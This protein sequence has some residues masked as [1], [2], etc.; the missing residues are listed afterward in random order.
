MRVL[1]VLFVIVPIAEM[2][3]LIKIGEQI[4]AT[5]TILAVLLTAVLGVALLRQQGLNTLFRVNQ[6]LEQG[7]L[8]AEEIIG[9]LCLAVGGALLLT[10]GFITD[11]AGFLCLLP[12]SRHLLVRFL[13]SHS[14]WQ[15]DTDSF[16]SQ[17]VFREQH[18]SKT[19]IE[20]E[21]KREE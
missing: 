21:F 5:L 9:G 10:P 2:W 11:V 16:D 1:F 3:L 14:R 12:I 15:E 6:R 7:Q 17:T 18:R 4:G 19:T 13:L 20:G 8:P